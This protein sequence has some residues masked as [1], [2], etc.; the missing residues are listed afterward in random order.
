MILINFIS[1]S[2]KGH[3]RPEKF[4]KQNQLFTLLANFCCPFQ[5]NIFLVKMDL[6][7]ERQVFIPATFFLPKTKKC[8]ILNVFWN[9]DKICK[10]LRLKFLWVKIA[11]VEFIRMYTLEIGPCIVPMDVEYTWILWQWKNC[12]IRL[13]AWL[14]FIG[15][16]V[17]LEGE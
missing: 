9:S 6:K 13:L 2:A 12:L 1:L 4:C 8:L 16:L 11:Y 10:Y 7:L 15:Q 5:F 17:N 14:S 3:F